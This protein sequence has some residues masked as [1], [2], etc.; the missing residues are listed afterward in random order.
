MNPIAS[1]GSK[2]M[3]SNGTNNVDILPTF[4]IQLY[5]LP[6]TKFTARD[7]RFAMGRNRSCLTVDVDAGWE[8][9]RRRRWRGRRWWRGRWLCRRRGR[10][11]R[12]EGLQP[13]VSVRLMQRGVPSRQQ[14][15]AATAIC[16]S[17]NDWMA[18]YLCAQ[19]APRVYDAMN[20]N[21]TWRGPS[22]TAPSSEHAQRGGDGHKFSMSHD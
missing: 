12:W 8:R 13:L 5:Q 1:Q 16:S 14:C 18:P 11:P 9:Q 7:L 22:R 2:L 6:G 10:W 17:P 4:Y 3:V 21:S 20:D 19:H 15:A